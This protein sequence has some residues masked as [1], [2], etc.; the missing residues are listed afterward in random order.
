MKYF[1]I[2]IIFF[3]GCASPR[4]PF[5]LGS[6]K[7]VSEHAVQ[8]GDGKQFDI[9]ANIRIE[10]HEHKRVSQI[11]GEQYAYKISYPT[12]RGKPVVEMRFKEKKGLS[13]KEIAGIVEKGHDIYFFA[14]MPEDN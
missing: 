14:N 7:I 1:L 12:G 3:V 13:P 6:T 10:L 5:D 4:S 2:L 11:V 8:F 9:R